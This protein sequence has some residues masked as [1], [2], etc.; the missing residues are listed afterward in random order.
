MSIKNQQ[1]IESL[2]K[3]FDKKNIENLFKFSNPQ[4]KWLDQDG[5]PLNENQTNIKDFRN[6]C[7][8]WTIELAELGEAD[9]EIFAVGYYQGTYIPK[10]SPFKLIFIHRYTF[11][12][13]LIV[14]FSFLIDYSS[15]EDIVD[16]DA[17]LN[18][19]LNED[20]EKEF[21]DEIRHSLKWAKENFNS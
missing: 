9:N 2:Y 8:E 15:V 12:E 11:K 7:K 3:P 20:P 6:N 4:T 18:E 13:E 5:F 16:L 19:L 1:T 10:N 17:D 21:Q 14:N